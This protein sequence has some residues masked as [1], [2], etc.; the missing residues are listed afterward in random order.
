MPTIDW[1]RLAVGVPLN[2]RQRDGSPAKPSQQAPWSRSPC[3]GRHG[4][5]SRFGSPDLLG[6]AII[7]RLAVEFMRADPATAGV[8]GSFFRAEA[9]FVDHR[10]DHGVVVG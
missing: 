4:S 9:S 2:R 1:D 10:L 5:G 8:G 3:G 7:V 6:E